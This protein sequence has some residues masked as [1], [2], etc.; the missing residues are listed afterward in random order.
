[1]TMFTQRETR[2]LDRRVTLLAGT[3][4]VGFNSVP[5]MMFDGA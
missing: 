2:I 5:L 1:M 4:S 3:T